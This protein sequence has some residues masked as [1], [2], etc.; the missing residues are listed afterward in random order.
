VLPNDNSGVR[1]STGKRY[2]RT[3]KSDD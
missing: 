2:N 3:Q 1:L